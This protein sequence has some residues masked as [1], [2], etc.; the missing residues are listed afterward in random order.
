MLAVEALGGVASKRATLDYLE[1]NE[2]IALDAWLR[3]TLTTRPEPRWRNMLSH[4]RGELE[5]HGHLLGEG[6]DRWTLTQT[7]REELARLRQQATA[8]LD[9]GE[10]LKWLGHRARGLL[11]VSVGDLAPTADR[12]E[13]ERRVQRLLSFPLSPPVG[14]V[15][16]ERVVGPHGTVF[17]TRPEGR[18]LDAP[19]G[20]GALRSLQDARPPSL[21]RRG[22]T[23]KFTMSYVSRTVDPIRLRTP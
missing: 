9:R 23:S 5:K 21:P 22:L 4:S 14:Q 3:E 13:L 6:K 18:R 2:L 16:P 7:G 11:A 8:C 20:E 10:P 1:Q 17:Q 15:S 12:D 19:G